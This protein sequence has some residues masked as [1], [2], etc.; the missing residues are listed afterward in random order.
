MSRKLLMLSLWIALVSACSS[1]PAV[2]DEGPTEEPEVVE[3]EAK[4]AED[5]EASYDSLRERLEE[6]VDGTHRSDANRA[7]DVY[8]NPVDTLRFFKVE[9]TDRVVE[10]SPGRGWYSEILGPYLYG[11]GTLVAAVPPI[12]PEDEESYLTQIVTEYMGFV[13][14]NRDTLGMVEVGTFAPPEVA[15]IGEPG[16]ADAV[17]TF[18]NLHGMYNRGTIEATLSAVYEVLRPGG[19]FGVVQHRAPE[20][21][22]PA[23]SA[24]MGYL[25]QEVVI[26]LAEAAGFVLD[27]ASE[28]NANPMDTADH[29]HGVWS[30]PP[31]LR[32][33][34]ETA[35]RYQEIGESD[36]MT[37]RFV[38][39]E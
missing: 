7:R 23:E 26:E 13:E 28:I 8:R 32:G 14:A 27:G 34:E 24:S 5:R 38:K 33:G 20:G 29:E 11:E 2:E 18:R 35:E 9:P 39:P 36:R 30:L 1:A 3:E 6:I 17:V 10:L 25:P 21:S 22:D 4:P 31:T 37:L 15:E 16:S 19:T 12:D